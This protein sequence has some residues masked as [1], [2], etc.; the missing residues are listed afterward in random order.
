MKFRFY[1]EVVFFLDRVQRLL[2][3]PRKTRFENAGE[4]EAGAMM[5]T[6]LAAVDVLH[7]RGWLR[8]CLGFIHLF[9]FNSGMLSVLRQ[10]TEESH[11]AMAMLL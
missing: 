3:S 9:H 1:L 2:G 7:L 11:I 6:A 8:S 4:F 10:V 5:A